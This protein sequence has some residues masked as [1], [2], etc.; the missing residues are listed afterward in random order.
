M[1]SATN[2]CGL[3][4]DFFRFV[5]VTK[6]FT[7]FHPCLASSILQCLRLAQSVRCCATGVAWY[8]QLWPQLLTRSLP[9]PPPSSL[10][11]RP[12]YS[13]SYHINFL[14][15]QKNFRACCDAL[16]FHQMSLK[17]FPSCFQILLFSSHWHS[18]DWMSHQWTPATKA[19]TVRGTGMA[20]LS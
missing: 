17:I 2:N 3:K 9:L 12:T 4:C 13:L 11:C 18:M 7:C 10:F 5:G 19:Q 15:Q 16:K 6:F 20:H 1:C 14:F 8:R